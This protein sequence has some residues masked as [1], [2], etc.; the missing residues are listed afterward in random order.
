MGSKHKSSILVKSQFQAASSDLCSKDGFYET[1]KNDKVN[2]FITFL[3]KNKFDGFV[4]GSPV[5][6]TSAA[7]FITPF[8]DR[9]FSMEN[10]LMLLSAAEKVDHLQHSTK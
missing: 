1:Y 6:Y 9:L 10:L 7:G 2:E 8:V 3:H 5:H 4:F